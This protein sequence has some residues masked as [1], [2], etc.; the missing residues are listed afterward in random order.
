M[1]KPKKTAVT[2]ILS[3][4]VG[5]SL[6]LLSGPICLGQTAEASPTSTSAPAPPKVKSLSAGEQADLLR[7][8]LPGNTIGN[9]GGFA[10]LLYAMEDVAIGSSSKAV[11]HK[12]LQSI[13]P[14][15]ETYKPTYS[16]FFDAIARQT[17]TSYR[18]EPEVN[19]W[20]FDQPQIPLPY[21]IKKADDWKEEDRGMYVAYIP[22]VA[23][24]GLDIYMM[25]RYSDVTE[26]QLKTIR[27]MTALRFSK[28]MN[29]DATAA[30]MNVATID[31]AEA[32]YFAADAPAKDRFWR[33]W[34]FFKNGQVFVIVSAYSKE[35]K[36]KVEADV[37]NMLKSFHVLETTPRLEVSTAKR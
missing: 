4:T 23:P 16:E 26:A 6:S 36:E 13:Y 25:G 22:P 7:R 18:Y 21:T 32:L 24:I 19:V 1:F 10:S 14:D 3:I 37:D 29:V 20:V 30:D 15:K 35:N 12:P 31:G 17:G 5:L 28:N 34:A 2:T 33:Q 8:R 11:L 9:F 27:D